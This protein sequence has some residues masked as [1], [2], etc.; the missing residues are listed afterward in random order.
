VR[1]NYS[2]DDPGLTAACAFVNL[3]SSNEEFWSK[4]V[5]HGRFDHT[6]Y[7]GAE[8]ASLMRAHTKTVEVRLY[9]KWIG[10][11]HRNTNAYVDPEVSG[12]I[13]Y[14]ERKLWRGKADK[15]CTLV[16][17]FVHVVD[18]D[19]SGKPGADF[20]HSGQRESG[21]ANA[22]PNWIGALAQTYYPASAG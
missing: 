14:N 21:N 22:A 2:G 16:H 1:L 13:F 17:E 9:R 15:V 6:P 12:V 7:S 10:L 3:L 19:E 5:A 18:H 4:I 11:L 20:T 8:I